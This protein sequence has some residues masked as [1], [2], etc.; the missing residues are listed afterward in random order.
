MGT[1]T[2]F[3]R[4]DNAQLSG[5][6]KLYWSVLGIVCLYIAT[7]LGLGQAGSRMVAP[8]LVLFVGLGTVW[9]QHKGRF[10]VAMTLFVWG[11]WGAVTVQGVFRNGVGNAALFAY[12]ALMILGGW[13]L[14][15][16]QGLLV[17]LASVAASFGLA[18][19][20]QRGWIAGR[21]LDAPA[22]MYWLPIGVVIVASMF[23]MRYVLRIHWDGVNRTQQ[24][25]GELEQAVSTLMARE[26]ALQRSEQRFLK[27]SQSNPLPI[28]VSRLDN[29]LYLAVN[30]AWQREFGWSE[31][32]VVGHTS[33][34]F[35]FWASTQDRAD[36]VR[37]VLRD[38]R[39][40]NRSIVAFSRDG[41]KLNLLL[42]AEQIEYDDHVCVLSIFVDQTDRL[43]IESEIKALNEQL[44]QRVEQ[45]T[46]ELTETL[47]TLK[48]A[49]DELVQSEKLASLGQLVAGVAHELNTPIGNALI[50]TSALGDATREF[51]LVLKKGNMKRSTLAH[52][53]AQCLE[54]TSLAERSLHRASDLLR[55]FKQVAV[56]R[57][58][59]RRREFDLREMVS[60]V[61]D[62]IRP[63]IK[64]LS[65]KMSVEIPTGIMLQSYPG[66]LGQVVI[67]LAMNAVVHA[68]D[69]RVNGSVVLH[70][71]SAEDAFVTL[72]CTDDGNGI[73]SE[74]LARIFEPFFTTK[75]G[76]GGSGLG[77]AIV[78]RLVTQVLCGQITVDSRIGVGTAFR[79][80][81]PY[82]VKDEDI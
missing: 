15:T 50:T 35:G 54:G 80:R 32:E 9:L 6:D 1:N 13:V 57:A 55:S 49:Q 10:L 42:S 58:S 34:E 73:A 45:R 23:A 7:L 61:V 19:S 76:Q 27:V 40:L 62:T 71:E 33:L 39:C 82:V 72:V 2:I 67:N 31:A 29:G 74:H 60:E 70:V 17:G 46:A 66:P 52:F 8:V 68:F 81:L 18:L 75:L 51:D 41:R 36:W 38:G 16:R 43:K 64:G 20:E 69:G 48:R 37:D 44:E 26:K 24:L 28:A 56:D 53:V 63:N 78:H 14:G 4:F 59:E 3:E 30:P 65:C 11:I 25:N 47:G 5:V 79:L 77:L 21:T 12:P 22:L